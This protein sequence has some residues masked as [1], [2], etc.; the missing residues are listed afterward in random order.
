MF[1]LRGGQV[2]A[3]GSVPRK[4]MPIPAYSF[5]LRAAEAAAATEVGETRTRSFLYNTARTDARL[6]AAHISHRK[7]RAPK[8]SDNGIHPNYRY[9][10]PSSTLT[11]FCIV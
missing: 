8:L 1:D 9:P 2:G 5:P 6:W 4:L 11:G 7:R 10:T 3:G